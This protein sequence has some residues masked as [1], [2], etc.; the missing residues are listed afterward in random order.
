MRPE[1]YRNW[2]IRHSVGARFKVRGTIDYPAEQRQR[3]IVRPVEELPARLDRLD[4]V[5]LPEMAETHGRRARGLRRS[6]RRRALRPE[7]TPPSCES[8]LCA[9]HERNT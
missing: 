9:G 8:I 6:R 2:P 4:G 5:R 7:K 1:K 3:G